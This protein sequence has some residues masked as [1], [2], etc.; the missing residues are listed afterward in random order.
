MSENFDIIPKEVIVPEEVVERKFY[1]FE[2]I[3]RKHFEIYGK[4]GSQNVSRALSP[5]QPEQAARAAK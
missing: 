3:H 5:I 2:A 1:D 4:N